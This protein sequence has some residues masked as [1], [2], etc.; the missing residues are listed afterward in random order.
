[1]IRHNSP[2]PPGSDKYM[3]RAAHLATV[4]GALVAAVALLVGVYEFTKTQRMARRNLELQMK[5]L[6][7][8]REIKA[9]ELFLKFNEQQQELA[10]KPPPRKGEAAFWRYNALLAATEAV[11]KLTARRRRLGRNGV[12]DAGGSAPIPASNR[13]QLQDVCRRFPLTYEKGCSRPQM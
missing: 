7:Q 13:V 3:E 6:L 5:T 11:F 8:D 9:I 10:A 4:V 2:M 1:M 12:V